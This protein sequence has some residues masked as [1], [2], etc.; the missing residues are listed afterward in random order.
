MTVMLKVT[1]RVYRI[2][3]RARGAGE[4]CELVNTWRGHGPHNVQVR[5]DRSGLLVVP[6]RRLRKVIAEPLHRPTN[7]APVLVCGDPDSIAFGKRAEI[8]LCSMCKG[9]GSDSE[10]FCPKKYGWKDLIE[11]SVLN[12]MQA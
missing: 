10:S 1:G 4:F 5:A 6:M 3:G 7:V 8:S 2:I 9:N 12:A 11:M